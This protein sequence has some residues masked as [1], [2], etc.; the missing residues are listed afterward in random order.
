MTRRVLVTGGLGFIGSNLVHEL[1]RRGMTVTVYDNHDP[2]C[3]GNVENLASLGGRVEVLADDIRNGVAVAG[4]VRGKDWIF[5][6]AAHTSHPMSMTDP[7]NDIDVNCRGTMNLLEA[8]RRY[9]PEAKLVHVGTSTQI[10]RSTSPVADELHPEF[11][12]DI[13]SANKTASEKYVLV[14]ASA[15][16]VRANVVRLANNFGPRS[17][18]RS[19]NFGFVNFFIGLALRGQELTVFGNG[20]QL[21]SIS[22]VQDS[23]DALILAAENDAVNG[24]VLFAVADRQTS[25]AEI[26]SAI[27]E[28]IGG[29]LRYVEWPTERAAIEIGDAVI[30]NAK[31][32]DKLGWKPRF[33]IAEGLKLT[34]DY[35]RPRLSH[36]L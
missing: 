9:A 28:Q 33:G 26:A 10:G 31:A 11:P 18:I 17:N 21:R 2:R 8:I 35:Y 12:V 25:V 36:Y 19:A 14:Y 27:A 20:A 34:A 23:I 5:H 16:R 13:Y 30:S 1:V 24:E 3:S 7:L 4:A 32:R 15:H 22:F 29:T 6:C